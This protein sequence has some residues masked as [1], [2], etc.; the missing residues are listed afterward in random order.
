M[1]A[2]P[3]ISQDFTNLL[4]GADNDERVFLKSEM[5]K[6]FLQCTLDHIRSTPVSGIMHAGVEN[7]RIYTYMLYNINKEEIVLKQV[8]DGWDNPNNPNKPFCVGVK[9]EC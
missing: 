1:D 7:L 8:A 5:G 4:A 2:L 3:E 6:K 9:E